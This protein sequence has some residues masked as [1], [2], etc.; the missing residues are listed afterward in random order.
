MSESYMHNKK[1]GA[2]SEHIVGDFFS[3]IDFGKK[4]A[5]GMY[6]DVVVAWYTVFYFAYLCRIKTVYWYEKYT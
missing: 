4:N 3:V 1:N 2:D 6:A 5:G